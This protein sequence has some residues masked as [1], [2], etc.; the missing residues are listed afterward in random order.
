MLFTEVAKESLYDA[1]VIYDYIGD[2]Q[3][4]KIPH[5]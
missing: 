1:V 2:Q 4:K 5:P 3:V